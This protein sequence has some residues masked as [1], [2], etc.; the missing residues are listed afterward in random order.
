MLLREPQ[1]DS[2]AHSDR[3]ILSRMLRADVYWIQKA[4][5]TM[6]TILAISSFAVIFLSTIL[7]ATS[8]RADAHH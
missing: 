1:N 7:W 2:P 8:R 4:R 5:W 3:R 6:M